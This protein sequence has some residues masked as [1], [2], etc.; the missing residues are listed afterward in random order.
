MAIGRRPTKRVGI[1]NNRN[2]A[3]RANVHLE[4]YAVSRAAHFETSLKVDAP[5]FYFWYKTKGSIPCSCIATNDGF[6]IDI[7]VGGE[8]ST[9][10][11]KFGD[12]NTDLDSNKV[13][14][15]RDATGETPSLTSFFKNNDS[16][17]NNTYKPVKPS[18][19]DKLFNG[20]ED[21]EAFSELDD[22]NL[23]EELSDFADP[24]NLFSDK[25]I[26]CAIC[27]DSGYIDGWNLHGGQ[28][29]VFD[30]SNHHKFHCTGVEINYHN[31]PTDLSGSE[32][33]EIYWSFK[34]PR[35]WLD[36]VRIGVFKGEKEISPDK[37]IWKWQNKDDVAENGLVTRDLL[38]GLVDS[39]K[40]IRLNL[41]L[42]DEVD[43]T[44][45]E[46]IFSYRSPY[47]AQIPEITQGYEDEF[48]D[49][50]VNLTVELPPSL[51]IN[52]G[53]YLTESKYGK[54]WKVSTLTRKSTAGGNV[55]GLT[56]DLRALHSFEK[57]FTQFS[58][59][60]KTMVDLNYNG[61]LPDGNGAGSDGVSIDTDNLNWSDNEW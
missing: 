46:I 45:A 11:T 19:D 18:L 53:N 21:D 48:L 30:T 8:N 2:L 28:R 12:N 41:T 7:E 1:P 33:S 40:S 57:K 47:K 13:T 32:G 54:V 29:F 16:V 44:H 34:L 42:V 49:W 50:N 5:Y 14:T 37:Y 58:L 3:N 43:F 25:A 55:Y 35:I 17:A 10:M 61:R 39:G 26:Q 60:R 6:N 22:S 36:I 15:Y 51:Q 27:M 31:N 9:S 23:K 4:N 59:F 20:E 56:A 24:L 38:N 52:E